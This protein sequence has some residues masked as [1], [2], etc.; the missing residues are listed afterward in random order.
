MGKHLFVLPAILLLSACA[1]VQLPQPDEWTDH[2]IIVAAGKKGDWDE[3]IYPGISSPSTAVVSGREIRIEG[4]EGDPVQADGDIV[5]TLPVDIQIMPGAL[6]LL[7]PA[8][9]CALRMRSS[10]PTTPRTTCR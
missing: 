3:R 7:M 8:G 6:K 1:S 2:G 5:A 10:A 4:P 9:G